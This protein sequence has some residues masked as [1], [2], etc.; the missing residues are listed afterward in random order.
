[1]ETT[2]GDAVIET[3][4]EDAGILGFS[5]FDFRFNLVF[6]AFGGRGGRSNFGGFV[7]FIGR[8]VGFVLGFIEEGGLQ[9]GGGE[10]TGGVVFAVI[11]GVSR[12][13]GDLMEFRELVG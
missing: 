12:G 8:A 4:A 7:V 13:D 1:M 11:V 2:A 5:I 6:F 9:S 10:L 3:M